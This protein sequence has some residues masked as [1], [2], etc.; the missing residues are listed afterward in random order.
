MI[1][2]HEQDVKVMAKMTI[3]VVLVNRWNVGLGGAALGR[4]QVV[5]ELLDVVMVFM[6]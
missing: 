5:L 1:T 4:Q 3:A 6:L 2:M